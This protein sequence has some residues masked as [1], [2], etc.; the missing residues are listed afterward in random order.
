MLQMEQKIRHHA[1]VKL[2]SASN[3]KVLIILYGS[4]Y[5]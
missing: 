2:V 4:A 3:K 1:D 5:F